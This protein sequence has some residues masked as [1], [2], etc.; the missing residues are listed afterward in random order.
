MIR[1]PENV[2]E[3]GECLLLSISCLEKNIEKMFG[4]ISD[5]IISIFIPND[6]LF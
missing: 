2:E 3:T 4:L 5:L 6:S 1:S